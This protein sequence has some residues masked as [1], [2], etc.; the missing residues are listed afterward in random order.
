MM[1]SS[2]R[3]QDR[4]QVRENEV[5]V[6]IDLLHLDT[7]YLL[8]E[9]VCMST[10]LTILTALTSACMF[11]YT[12]ITYIITSLIY[13]YCMYFLSPVHALLPQSLLLVT[14]TFTAAELQTF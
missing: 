9:A 10:G 2:L 13:M 5:G 14:E 11:L 6:W 4:E 1:A 8:F 12:Y 7:V 3:M